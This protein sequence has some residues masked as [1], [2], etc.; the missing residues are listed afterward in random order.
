MSNYRP[1]SI[2]TSSS[3]I[4]EKVMHSRI[5]N[6]K[7]I[8]NILNKAQYGFRIN[9]KTDNAT[10]KLTTEILNALNN[11]SLVGGIFCDLQKAFDCV[12][13]KILLSKLKFYGI[14]NKDLKLYK[15]YL[16]N[17]YQRISIYKEDDLDNTISKWAR[18]K[19]GI[20]Q[21]SVLGPLLFLLYV[22]IYPRTLKIFQ[23]LF[24]MLITLV[25]YCLILILVI[26][27]II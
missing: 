6:H 9:L 20:K 2:L 25:F 4:F 17:R 23:Y 22:M 10:Y 5:L 24:Y 12:N 15:S 13:H 26:L 1:I 14:N 3:N 7:I 27:P 11:K 8:Y 19:H 18:V 21:G 16:E